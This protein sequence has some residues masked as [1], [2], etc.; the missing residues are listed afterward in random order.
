MQD[1]DIDL[2]ATSSQEAA[3]ESNVAINLEY[4]ADLETLPIAQLS[5]S[6]IGVSRAPDLDVR[7]AR[8]RPPCPDRLD[9]FHAQHRL[10]H[11]SG[12]NCLSKEE[13]GGR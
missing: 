11:G 2:G 3:T 12:I 4:Q 7:A 1:T 6:L 9:K 10:Y 8:F 13:P 5:H